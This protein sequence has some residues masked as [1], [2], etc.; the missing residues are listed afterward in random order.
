MLH[1]LEEKY[2]SKKEKDN[3]IDDD[4]K[5]VE[6]NE[7][8]ETDNDKLVVNAANNSPPPQDTM[9]TTMAAAADEGGDDNDVGTED[10]NNK[11]G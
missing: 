2:E 11:K 4:A 10:S 3:N 9:N 5:E 6:I 1:K 7:V 8:A